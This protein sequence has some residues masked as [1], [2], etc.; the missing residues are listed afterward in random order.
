MGRPSLMRRDQGAVALVPCPVCR[1]PRGA[2]CT[3]D[4]G[5]MV[6]GGHP[7]AHTGRRFDARAQRDQLCDECGAAPGTPCDSPHG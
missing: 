2:A 7:T 6:R 5:P 1:V 3:E 4:D